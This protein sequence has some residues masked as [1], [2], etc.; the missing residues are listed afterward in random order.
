MDTTKDYSS[1]SLPRR[2]ASK[3]ASPAMVP[4]VADSTISANKSRPDSAEPPGYSALSDLTALSPKLKVITFKSPLKELI[5]LVPI[6]FP[7]AWP[8]VRRRSL[9]Y[10]CNF[11]TSLT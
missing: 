7:I 2:S 5:V 1:Y 8:G 10:L 3:Y 9:L 4:L 6:C 11:Y